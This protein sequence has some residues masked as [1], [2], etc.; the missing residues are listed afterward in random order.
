MFG[1]G[2][3]QYEQFNAIGKKVDGLLSTLGGERIYKL[4]LGDDN[5]TLEVHLVRPSYRLSPAVPATSSCTR[6]TAPPEEPQ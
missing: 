2:N 3:T 6:L 1:L 5:G 4:G